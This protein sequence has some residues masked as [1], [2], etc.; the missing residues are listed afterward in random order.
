MGRRLKRNLKRPYNRQGLTDDQQEEIR[1]L[2]TGR[3][4]VSQIASKIK[5]QYQLVY[6]FVIREN[7]NVKFL[8]GTKAET[9]VRQKTSDK[10]FN[11]NAQHWY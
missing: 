8:P 10:L 2:S 7:L 6:G 4:T 1:M 3:L 11:V 5:V 9:T